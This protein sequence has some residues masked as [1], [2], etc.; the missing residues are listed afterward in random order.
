MVLQDSEVKVFTGELL[1]LKVNLSNLSSKLIQ[2]KRFI[3]LTAISNSERPT[4][5]SRVKISKAVPVYA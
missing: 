5:F 3:G 2:T 4:T 1:R